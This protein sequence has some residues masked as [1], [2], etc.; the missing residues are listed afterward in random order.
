MRVLDAVRRS[1]ADGGRWTEV[2][3]AAGGGR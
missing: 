3:E 1:A 2:G